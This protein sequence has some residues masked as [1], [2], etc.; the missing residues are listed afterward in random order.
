M[1][2]PGIAVLEFEVSPAGEGS[3]VVVSAHFHPAGAAGLLYWY[4]LW[5]L[6]KRIFVGLTE[7]IVARALGMRGPGVP[8]GERVSR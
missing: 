1:K 5:P 3:R 8:E 2:L 7:A 4:A 6:H